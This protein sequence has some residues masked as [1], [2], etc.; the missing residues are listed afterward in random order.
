MSC[1]SGQELRTTKRLPTE[2]GKPPVQ[3]AYS[4]NIRIAKFTLLSGCQHATMINMIT[5]RHNI[6]TRLIAKAIS[7]LCSLKVIMVEA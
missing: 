6:A 3:I 4:V 5:E 1:S 2:T 7:K